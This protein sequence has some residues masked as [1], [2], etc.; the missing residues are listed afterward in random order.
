M[1]KYNLQKMESPVGILYLVANEKNL[2]GVIYEKMWVTFKEQFNDLV[3]EENPVT[4]DTKSQLEEYFAGERKSFELPFEVDG[5]DFQKKVWMA[6]KDIPFGQTKTYKQQA[7]WIASPK[8][9]R[10]VG[11]TNGLNPLSIVLPCHR[12]V[13]SNGS[14]TGYAGGLEAKEYLLNLEQDEA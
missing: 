6:L 2:C 10:A 1:K 14:L 4:Q 3:E 12:V 9:V 5:T 8:A 11:R 7:E 13:G